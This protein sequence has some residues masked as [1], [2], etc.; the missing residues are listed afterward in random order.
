MRWNG[1][2]AIEAE[3]VRRCAVEKGYKGLLQVV[4]E[5]KATCWGKR[6]WLVWRKAPRST[7]RPRRRKTGKS[8]IKKKLGFAV[9][10]QKPRYHAGF[11][12][13]V[14]SLQ[15]AERTD[16]ERRVGGSKK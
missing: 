13:V 7:R 1:T 2:S 12:S 9:Q 3:C 16:G 4:A 10:R 8:R 6:R 5:G 14:L 11:V 15:R